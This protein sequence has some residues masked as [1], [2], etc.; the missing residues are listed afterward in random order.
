[1]IISM[2]FLV[3]YSFLSKK[4]IL[5]SC[6]LGAGFCYS[7]LIFSLFQNSINNDD[8][9]DPLKNEWFD[10]VKSFFDSK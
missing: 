2:L 5:K 7:L 3:A 8:N 6:F 4:I 9:Q 10:K 1:M